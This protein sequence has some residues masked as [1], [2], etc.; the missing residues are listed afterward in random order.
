[1]RASRLISCAVLVWDFCVWAWARAEV[2]APVL[3]SHGA[4]AVHQRAHRVY[5][6]AWVCCRNLPPLCRVDLGRPA[7]VLL[8][9]TPPPMCV[10]VLVYFV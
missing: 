9:A 5:M 6:C 8:V 4:P 3:A 1:M 2:E 10:F 7:N